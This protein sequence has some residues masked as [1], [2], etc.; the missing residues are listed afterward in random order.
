MNSDQSNPTSLKKGEFIRR[1]MLILAISI[2]LSVVLYGVSAITSYALLI[3]GF[4][5]LAIYVIRAWRPARVYRI[6]LPNFRKTTAKNDP[7]VPVGWL[8]KWF[9]RFVIL[10]A[11]TVLLSWLV[12]LLLRVNWTA[13]FESS[14]IS[15]SVAGFVIVVVL[16]MEAIQGAKVGVR[17]FLYLALL[18]GTAVLLWTEKVEPIARLLA[19]QFGRADFVFSSQIGLRWL[20]SIAL[21]IP[22]SL[23]ITLISRQSIRRRGNSYEGLRAVLLFAWIIHVL[24]LLTQILFSVFGLFGML[25]ALVGTIPVYFLAVFIFE[26][27]ILTGPFPDVISEMPDALAQPAMT[28]LSGAK[29]ILTVR[30]KKDEINKLR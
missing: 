19:E 23:A 28:L 29:V 22:L 13:V 20:S 7:S 6:R 11:A 21:L 16:V 8:E 25:I 14:R 4:F 10:A 2:L 24:L 12:R 18:L 15:V 27:A 5:V 9:N 1:G 30:S 26:P 3:V 17:V